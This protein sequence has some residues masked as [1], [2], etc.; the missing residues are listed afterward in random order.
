MLVTPEVGPFSLSP[1]VNVVLSFVN[2]RDAS[3]TFSR[4]R[5]SEP[6]P[7]PEPSVTDVTKPM[8]VAV[9]V[10]TVTHFSAADA[11]SAPVLAVFTQS[12][13]LPFD[14]VA[15]RSPSISN[16]PKSVFVAEP[17]TARISAAKLARGTNRKTRRLRRLPRAPTIRVME[18]LLR[19][20]FARAARQV[21]NRHQCPQ[22][23]SCPALA[24]VPCALLSCTC[25]V[26][27]PRTGTKDGR[28]PQSLV[29]NLGPVRPTRKTAF[30][31]SCAAGIALLKRGQPTACL[32]SFR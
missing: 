23:D 15:T 18:I 17:A 27:S 9:H 4:S 25:P 22:T 5:N 1:F 26:P 13:V 31:V 14:V 7:V 12:S 32:R 2:P 30:S 20:R 3:P 21:S 24:R 28:R 29:D 19:S 16:F 11:E 8:F 6:S 10:A